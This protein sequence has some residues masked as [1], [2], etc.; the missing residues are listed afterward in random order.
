MI[1]S[2]KDLIYYLEEDKIALFNEDKK[3]PNLF[4]DEIWKFEVLLKNE[5]C[6]KCLK[7]ILYSL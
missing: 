7:K 4:K 2:K 6:T 3:R 1:N 5:H